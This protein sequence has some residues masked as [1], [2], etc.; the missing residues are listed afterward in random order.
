MLERSTDIVRLSAMSDGTFFRVISSTGSADCREYKSQLMISIFDVDLPPYLQLGNDTSALFLMNKVVV[1]KGYPTKIMVEYVD[2]DIPEHA[3]VQYESPL[4]EALNG[5]YVVLDYEPR[6]ERII[7]VGKEGVIMR[8]PRNRGSGT[9]FV[10][11]R[12]SRR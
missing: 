8:K 10:D 12:S 11:R 6:Q 4:G 3:I 2:F 1:Q 7:Q 9:S 5:A